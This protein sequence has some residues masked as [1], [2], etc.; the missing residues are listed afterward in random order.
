M[1]SCIM[2]LLVAFVLLV[3]VQ[4]VDAADHLVAGNAVPQ[5]D[6]MTRTRVASDDDDDEFDWKKRSTDDLFANKR[7]VVFALPG[8]FTP[9]CSASH[10]PGYDVA[11]DEILS[12]G[13]DDVYCISVNDVRLLFG[14]VCRKYVYRC[15]Q[16]VLCVA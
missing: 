15:T 9:T 1:T 6:F 7:V 2:L 14:F 4:G 12:H 10:V 5:V 16:L 13:V 3:V 8:A 11:Y